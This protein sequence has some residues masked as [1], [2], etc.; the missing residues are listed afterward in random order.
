MAMVIEYV[1]ILVLKILRQ[2]DLKTHV[3]HDKSSH[4]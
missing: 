4:T 2:K 3:M 1:Y